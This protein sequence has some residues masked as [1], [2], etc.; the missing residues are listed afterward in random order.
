MVRPMLPR[1]RHSSPSSLSRLLLC[2]QPLR[3]RR[4]VQPLHMLHLPPNTVH[5][6]SLRV[7]RPTSPQHRLAIHL[8]LTANLLCPANNRLRHCRHRLAVAPRQHPWRLRPRVLPS[9]AT[10]VVGT[11]YQPMLLPAAPLRTRTR[12][13]ASPQRSHRRSQMRHLRVSCHLPHQRT[14]SRQ[15]RCRHRHALVV[16]NRGRLLL[17][18]VSVCLHPRKDLGHTLPKVYHHKDP[19]REWCRR[20]SA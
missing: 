3:T 11:M 17:R 20:P 6:Q 7:N 15:Q 10:M 14:D 16:C 13:R 4:M 9:S 19:R 1:C 5:R 12:I 18:K 8:G 2:R